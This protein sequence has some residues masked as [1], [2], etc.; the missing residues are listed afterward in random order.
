[1]FCA[2][3]PIQM[4]ATHLLNRSNK[5]INRVLRIC[6]SYQNKNKDGPEAFASLAPVET[7]TEAV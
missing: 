2:M 7:A 5:F 3:I 6:L 1:M 4:I